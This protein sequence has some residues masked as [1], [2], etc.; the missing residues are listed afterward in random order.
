MSQEKKNLTE[1]VAANRAYWNGMADQW[2]KAGE[3]NWK[4]SE[5]TW[6]T[7]SH[8]ESSLSLL[9]KDMNGMKA[10]E[11]GCGTGY[12]SAWM[13]R[14]GAKVVGI[15]NSEAQ[16]ETAKRLARVHGI[17]MELIHGNAEEVPYPDESFDFAI[18]EYEAA[19]WCN[20]WVPEAAR[21][22]KPGGQLVLLVNH[23]M[24]MITTPLNRDPCEDKLHRS[25]F[26]MHKYDCGM[27]KPIQEE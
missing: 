13:A 6:G 14:R 25:Y 11:L 19:I 24:A 21:L 7:W 18:S 10:I 4:T 8:P 26:G 1:H 5:P 12:V 27:W 3:E 16:L 2:V 23:P 17:D 22:L 15:D 9:P 20:K